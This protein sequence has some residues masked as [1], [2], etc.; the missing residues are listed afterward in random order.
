MVR[1]ETCDYLRATYDTSEPRRLCLPHWLSRLRMILVTFSVAFAMVVVCAHATLAKD[2]IA[3][4]RSACA[5]LKTRTSGMV[6]QKLAGPV[7]EWSCDFVA[8]P[9]YQ[10]KTYFVMRLNGKPCKPNECGS[11]LL[12]WYA[13]RKSDGRAFEWNIAE[14][15]LGKPL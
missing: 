11:N 13:V 4:Q 12:G 7:A 8:P 1:W 5:V 15:V 14:D 9:Q 2:R 6:D 3:T 10:Q